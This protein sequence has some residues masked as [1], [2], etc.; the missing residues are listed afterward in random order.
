MYLKFNKTKIVWKILFAFL[1]SCSSPVKYYSSGDFEKAAKIDAHFHYLTFDK[2]Y[3]E[4]ASSLNFRL[5]SPNWDWNNTMDEQMKISESIQDSFPGKYTF[6]GTFSVDSFNYPGFADKTIARIKECI[7]EGASG[8]KIWKNIGMVLKDKNGKYVMIDDPAFEP[9]FQYLEKNKIPVIGHL[10]EPKDC[11]L[12]F[13]KMTDPGDVS[14]YK[15]NPQYYMFMHPE[16]P[17]YD[18]QINARDNILKKYPK[19]DFIGAHLASLEWSVDELAKRLDK[20]PNLKVD[21]AARMY[22]LQYQSNINREKV[23]DFMIKYQDRIL[24]ATDNEVYDV[25]G[26]DYNTTAENLRKGWLAQWIYLATDS[27]NGVKGLKLPADVIDKIY[28]KNAIQY[29]NQEK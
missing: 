23:R 10:G 24:Y 9:V 21:L 17:S 6:F 4:Y 27:V 13:D 29:F 15:E 28:F 16:V 1:I 8:I 25:A 26:R 20:Y 3:M 5:L 7:A 19:L 12:P 2:R 18:E 14:Y 22:H 11:W